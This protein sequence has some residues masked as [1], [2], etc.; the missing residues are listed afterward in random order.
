MP[1]C[2]AA[3]F[4][5]V[6]GQQDTLLANYRLAVITAFSDVDRALTGLKRLRGGKRNSR[7]SRCKR[8]VSR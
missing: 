8:R 2:C 4:D 7:A 1:A 6:K 3:Q 5:E